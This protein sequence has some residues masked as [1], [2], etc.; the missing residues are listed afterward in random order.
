VF[1]KN[2]RQRNPHLL[3]MAEGKPCLLLSVE[4]C[5]LDYGATTVAAHQNEHKGKG[6]KRHDFM[7]V[8][9][10]GPCHTWYDQSGSPLAEKRRAFNAAHARQIEEWRKIAESPTAKPKD[11]AAAKWALDR[12]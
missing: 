2:P 3:A 11:I 8:W 5:Q 1:S 9:G 12:V 10:C 7:S 4:N 6:I